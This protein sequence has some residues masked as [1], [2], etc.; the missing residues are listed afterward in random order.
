[1]KTRKIILLAAC[2]ILLVIAI[3]QGVTKTTDTVKTIALKDDIDEIKIERPGE[4][5]YMVKTGE[6]WEIG[7]QKYTGNRNA[8]NDLAE[9][10]KE[11][12]LL[13]KVTKSDNEEVLAKYELNSEKV[14]KVTVSSKGAVLKTVYVGKTN[15]TNSQVYIKLDS[16]DD[17]Y[18]ASG[19]LQ[20][21]CLKPVNDFRSKAVVQV[22]KDDITSIKLAPSG[23]E[24]WIMNRSAEGNVWTVAGDAV[25]GNLEIDDEVAGNWFQTC[26]NLAAVNWLD[27]NAS[28][29]GEK[30]VDVEMKLSDRTIELTVTKGLDEDGSDAYWAKSSEVPYLC[31]IAKYSAEKYL[32][33]PEDFAK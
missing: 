27:D 14:C 11:I 18:L 22:S 31:K 33:N 28:L 20:N 13:N 3:I 16:S 29:P 4:D 6:D 21:D 7:T 26:G 19:K 1:M 30:L 24:S 8:C 15:S 17:V 10:F 5:L 12:K 25:K 2:A 9:M 23:G 32:K